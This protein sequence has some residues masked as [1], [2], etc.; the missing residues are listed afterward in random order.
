M[1]EKAHGQEEGHIALANTPENVKPPYDTTRD[2]A[3]E[4]V[5]AGAYRPGVLKEDLRSKSM[6]GT[7]CNTGPG[8]S[9]TDLTEMI[10]SI[11]VDSTSGFEGLQLTA[12]PW[13]LGQV[14]DAKAKGMLASA[15][16]SFNATEDESLEHVASSRGL[17]GTA[18]AP[19]DAT[20]SSYSDLQCQG[21]PPAFSRGAWGSLEKRVRVR[22]VLFGEFSGSGVATSS[23]VHR[24]HV[25]RYRSDMYLGTDLSRKGHKFLIAVLWSYRIP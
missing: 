15:S 7:S 19:V 13:E 23:V 12:E 18:G 25:F 4:E 20:C 17:C 8:L 11:K 1:S 14:D 9:V 21:W 24:T 10:P 16:G 3:V 6:E 22:S 5:D 2:T